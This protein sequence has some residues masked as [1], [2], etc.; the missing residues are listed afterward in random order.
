[1]LCFYLGN[2]ET[3]ACFALGLYSTSSV[4]SK[5]PLPSCITPSQAHSFQHSDAQRARKIVGM[6]PAPGT[7]TNFS[8]LAVGFATGVLAERLHPTM[9]E[10][11]T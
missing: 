9:P 4:R 1:M 8:L 2:K 3:F 11:A 5:P 7:S 10:I 6:L